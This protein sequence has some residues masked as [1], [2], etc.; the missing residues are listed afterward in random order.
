[1]QGQKGPQA[2]DVLFVAEDGSIQE[3]ISTPKPAKTS[4]EG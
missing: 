2:N 4:E 1:V 3:V